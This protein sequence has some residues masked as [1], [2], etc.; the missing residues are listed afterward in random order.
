MT[1]ERTPLCGWEGV[2]P[3]SPDRLFPC[4]KPAVGYVEG[5]HGT[6]TFACGEHRIWAMGKEQ[7]GTFIRSTRTDDSDPPVTHH[8]VSAQS[9]HN[10]AA[11]GQ[12]DSE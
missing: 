3:D 2:S 4:L 12:T 1:H 5:A 9:H 7:Q 6:R 11:V 8:A 10:F